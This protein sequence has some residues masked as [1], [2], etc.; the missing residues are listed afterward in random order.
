MCKHPYS[1]TKGTY[2]NSPVGLVA[3]YAHSV[4][5]RHAV[6]AS[7]NSP[8]SAVGPTFYVDITLHSACYRSRNRLASGLTMGH[9]LDMEDVFHDGGLY[10]GL[11]RNI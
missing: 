3:N 1:F 7:A 9:C 4:R 5:R 6:E 2:F 10:V 11:I 8:H